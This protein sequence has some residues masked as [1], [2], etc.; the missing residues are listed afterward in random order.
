MTNENVIGPTMLLQ[1]HVVWSEIYQ[2]E[3]K[4][5][6][7][8]RRVYTEETLFLFPLLFLPSIDIMLLNFTLTTGNALAHFKHG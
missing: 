6:T 1:G 3:K 4:E 8:F 2:S 7:T 5:C